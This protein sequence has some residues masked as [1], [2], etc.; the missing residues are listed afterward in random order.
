MAERWLL[1]DLGG[2]NTR[3][4]LARDGVLVPD[5]VQ[6]FRNADHPG[7]ID[8]L[9]LYLDRHPGPVAAICAGVAGPVQDGTAQLTNYDWFID[10][11]DLRAATGATQAH[12]INDLQ[13]QGYAL[14]DLPKGAVQTLFPGAA[15]PV[16]A[17]RLVL[18]LGTGCNVAVVHCTPQGLFVPAAES[19]HSMLPHLPDHADLLAHLAKTQSN[20][21]IEAALSGPG[22]SNIHAFVTGTRLPPP[23]IITAFKAGDPD[24]HTT[25]SAFTQILAHT[26]GN[27]TLHHLPMGGIYLTGSTA[28]AVAPYLADLEFYPAFTARGPYTEIVRRIPVAVIDDDGFPLLGCARYLHQ[29]R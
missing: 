10:S 14:D 11:A 19:G 27:F 23:D 9:S 17:T 26:T 4:A 16:N 6:S 5:S 24:A 21:P 29:K 8:L 22:L 7:F 18:N 28:C 25:L 20:L 13:A 3:I 15:A 1:A 12:L 2:T